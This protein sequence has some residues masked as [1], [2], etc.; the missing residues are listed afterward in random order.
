MC[1]LFLQGVFHCTVWE[2]IQASPLMLRKLLQITI[3]LSCDASLTNCPGAS[4]R[5][6]AEAVMYL[7]TGKDELR[8][9]LMH[10]RGPW[11]EAKKNKVVLVQGLT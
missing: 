10:P 9:Y 7:T 1:N 8:D 3:P 2:E 11:L 6:F 4:H 5:G